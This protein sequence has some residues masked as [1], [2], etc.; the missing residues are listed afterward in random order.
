M[1][2]GFWSPGAPP[3]PAPRRLR[4][5]R[6][7]SFDFGWRYIPDGGSAGRAAR[8]WP[9][10]PHKFQCAPGRGP[11][12]PG[13][14]RTPPPP[15]APPE[16]GRSFPSTRGAALGPVPV[17]VRVEVHPAVL[18]VSLH[19]VP[20][21]QAGGEDS[22][23]SPCRSVRRYQ[24]A[25]KGSHAGYGVIGVGL[26]GQRGAVSLPGPK[27]KIALPEN[28]KIALPVFQ[29]P[30]QQVC[31]IG[32]HAPYH[33]VQVQHPLEGDGPCKHCLPLDT[34]KLLLLG[35]QRGPLIQPNH[36]RQH[37]G[38]KQIPDNP[39]PAAPFSPVSPFHPVSSSRSSTTGVVTPP[40]STFS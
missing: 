1:F 37:Q 29:P 30:K 2:P 15:G 33:V 32:S 5:K 12:P 28:N 25:P 39:D 40:L 35:K 24:P 27:D 9:P 19:D 14:S 7:P 31:V 38:Q 17:P 8:T 18:V 10:A 36:P 21:G 16:S 6:P 13:R 22:R 4:H 23:G 3:G 26:R 20:P 34:Q 11:P